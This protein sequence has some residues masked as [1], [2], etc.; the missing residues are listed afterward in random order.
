MHKKLMSFVSNSIV[1]RTP[2]NSKSPDRTCLLFLLAFPFSHDF[3][4]SLSLYLSILLVSAW[5][6][7][8]E[9][10]SQGRLYEVDPH[11]GHT[12]QINAV[13]EGGNYESFAFDDQDPIATRYFTTEDSTNGAL[14]RY[15][16]AASAYTTGS[17]YDI[18]SSSGGTYEYLVLSGG[19][20]T[21][22]FT[23]STSR[24]AG[25]S[26]AESYFQK[27]EGI[28]VFDR[29]LFFV[30]KSQKE[31]FTLDLAAGT[32][33]KS[34]T[35]SGQFNLQPDQLG[36]MLG[37]GEVL[38]FC[39]DGGSDCDIHGHDSTGQYFTI[40]EGTDYSTETTG[41]AFSPD[42]MFM[43]VAFQGNSNVYSFWRDDGL[44]FSGSTAGTK[45]H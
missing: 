11:T 27:S 18:L 43:Y 23:W 13:D 12:R 10:G 5:V 14:V 36:R 32:F 24:S 29:E 16:P 38:Y 44:P 42:N 33:T 26:S 4:L 37:E 40:V 1:G 21:G 34:S 19:G 9:N 6:T 22:T 28:D 45:Y 2:W 30:S 3:S 35:L 7:C 20:S 15:T 39:E 31:L 25:E 8:E 17:N 41:L